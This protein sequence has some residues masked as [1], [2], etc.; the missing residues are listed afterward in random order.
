MISSFSA[1][2]LKHGLTCGRVV[3][4]MVSLVPKRRG[5]RTL[6]H[7]DVAAVGRVKISYTQVEGK[8]MGKLGNMRLREEGGSSRHCPVDRLHDG[9]VI[10]AMDGSEFIRGFY[11]RGVS[12]GGANVSD[13]G[14][15]HAVVGTFT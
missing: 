13:G 8:Q 14:Y 7:D 11:V 1:G 2:L 5:A 10:L 6:T 4:D 15:G 3:P 12:T 9:I